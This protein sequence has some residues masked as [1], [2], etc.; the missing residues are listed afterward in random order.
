MHFHLTKGGDFSPSEISLEKNAIS[1]NQ[2]K[3]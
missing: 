2:Q 3:S 1:K